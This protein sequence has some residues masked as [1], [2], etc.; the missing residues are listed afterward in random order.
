MPYRQ[1]GFTYLLA[2]FAVGAIGLVALRAI[3][4]VET[5]EQREKEVELI[6]VGQQF[7][8]AI[9]NYYQSTPGTLK[10]YPSKLEDLILDRR[11]VGIKRH[12]RRI[13]VDPFTCQSQWGLVKD[14]DGGIRGVYS[15]H[16][17]QPIKQEQF[18]EVDAGLAGAKSYRE[19]QFVYVPKPL[20][21][22]SH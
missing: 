18:R 5:F 20:S 13:Y 6:Y 8:Q 10:R 17:G 12:L 15:L 9:G 14:G 19:W 16:D 7:R 3:P 11:F 1:N 22:A 21:P 2:L 4:L